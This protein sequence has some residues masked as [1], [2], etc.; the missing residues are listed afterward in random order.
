MMTQKNSVLDVVEAIA[1]LE[2]DYRE[3]IK[4]EN[5]REEKTKGNLCILN[6]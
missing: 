5:N 6:I 2:V 4:S 1:E 3:A